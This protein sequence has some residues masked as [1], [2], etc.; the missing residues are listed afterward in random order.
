MN[1]SA[2]PTTSSA[3]HSAGTTLAS[4]PGTHPDRSADSSSA[5]SFS[6]ESEEE[7]IDYEL[8]PSGSGLLVEKRV[9]RRRTSKK[10]KKNP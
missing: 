3:T 5:T 9:Q 6:N 4:Q 2:D 8:D 7:E 10:T 1:S